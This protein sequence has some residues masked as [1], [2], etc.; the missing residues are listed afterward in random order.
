MPTQVQKEYNMKQV[1]WSRP[2]GLEYWH[3]TD[4][5]IDK[6]GHLLIGGK[7]GSG[8]SVV[9]NDYLYSLTARRTPASARFV[10]IDPKR[11]ELKAW[12]A[13]PFCWIYAN[14]QSAIIS[15]LDAVIAE[16]ED[17]YRRMESSFQRLYSGSEIWVV[18]DELGDLMTTCRRD[19]LPRMQR[20]AQ[21]GRAAR[22][23][24]ICGTQS[25]SRKT[26]PAELTLNFTHQLALNCRSAIESKQIIGIAGAE[27]L[28]RYGVG[29]MND[30]TNG[31]RML[32]I[33]MTSDNEIYERIRVWQD[34]ARKHVQRTNLL[35]RMFLMLTREYLA[36]CG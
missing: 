25:P 18:V 6:G 1:T 13:T 22:I 15:A 3:I 19:F 26:I 7:T 21:L 30:P 24:L 11:V 2:D 14:E 12:A 9:I 33:P 28:P 17:R 34:P 5:L 20:I 8:K 10:L 29:L 4:D 35:K 16:M 31:V 36:N 27:T 23:N 32:K